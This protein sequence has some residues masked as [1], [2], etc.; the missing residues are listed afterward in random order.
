MIY[1]EIDEFRAFPDGVLAQAANH[2]VTIRENGLRL[3]VLIPPDLHDLY[4]LYEAEHWK[5]PRHERPDIPDRNS[6]E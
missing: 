3:G 5:R 4:R 6:H 2:I 1:V